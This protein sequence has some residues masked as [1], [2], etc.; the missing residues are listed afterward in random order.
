ME[1]KEGCLYIGEGVT[2]VGNINLPDTVYLH[3]TIEG[4]ITA[5]EIQIGEKGKA[6]GNVRVETAEVKGEVTD[7]IHASNLLIVRSTGRIKGA[8]QYQFI[9]IEQGAVI[10]GKLNK[11]SSEKPSK[12]AMA[13]LTAA[14]KANKLD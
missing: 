4:E 2:I 7:S 13:E 1:E 3:G 12:A 10:E 8:L 14:A 6:K 5:K 9:E 11:L